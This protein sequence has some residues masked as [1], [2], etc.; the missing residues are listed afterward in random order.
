MYHIRWYSL[1]VYN[2]CFFLL[3]LTSFKE[4]SQ[5]DS[6]R[7]YKST[8][9]DASLSTAV[10]AVSAHGDLSASVFFRAGITRR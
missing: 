5:R 7:R 2:G 10:A 8:L 1:L 9:F 4:V 3:D 6:S